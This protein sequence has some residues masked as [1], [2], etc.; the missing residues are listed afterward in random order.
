[1]KIEL[2]MNCSKISGHDRCLVPII[3][4]IARARAPGP[5]WIDTHEK[6]N[7]NTILRINV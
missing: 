4:I 1:M 7:Y 5:V 6:Y 2:S 3:Q